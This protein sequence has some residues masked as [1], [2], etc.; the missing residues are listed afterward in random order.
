M[1]KK[2]W[3]CHLSPTLNGFDVMSS[4]SGHLFPDAGKKYKYL[5]IKYLQTLKGNIIKAEKDNAMK[6]FRSTES[7]NLS[8][9]A[10][11][12]EAN[13]LAVIEHHTL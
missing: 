2:P 12:L 4:L 1:V 7:L 13:K 10:Y 3:T 6:E 9:T 8:W 5:S 11:T